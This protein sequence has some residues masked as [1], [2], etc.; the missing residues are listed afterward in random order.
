MY[1]TLFGDLS[2]LSL[3]KILP[4]ECGYLCAKDGTP[5]ANSVSIAM[6]LQSVSILTRPAGFKERE[7]R[8]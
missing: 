8:N 5:D 2:H 1:D 7:L 4:F 3:L 6:I